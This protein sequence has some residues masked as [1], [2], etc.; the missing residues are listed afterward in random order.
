MPLMQGYL[1][2]QDQWFHTCRVEGDVGIEH[3]VSHLAACAARPVEG[4]SDEQMS[5]AHPDGNTLQPC[6]NYVVLASCCRVLISLFLHRDLGENK[7]VGTLPVFGPSMQE[8]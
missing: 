6:N 2:Q 5:G 4:C 1:E 7:L 8:A 3:C